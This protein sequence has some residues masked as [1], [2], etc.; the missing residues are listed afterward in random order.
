LARHV[1]EAAAILFFAYTGY[2]RIA[3]LAE[4][5]REPKRTIPRAIVITIG[6]AVL[7][8]FGVALVAVGAAGAGMLAATAAPLQVAA[9]S[10]AAPWVAVVVSSAASRRCSA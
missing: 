3:T 1:L 8:Y 7:L 10:F 9:E 4:E 2:A 5:V 6:G